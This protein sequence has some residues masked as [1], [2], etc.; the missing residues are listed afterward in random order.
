MMQKVRHKKVS[1][2]FQ[3]H[4]SRKWKG[5]SNSKVHAP[6]THVILPITNL[7]FFLEGSTFCIS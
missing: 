1:E 2:M 6:K 3:Y 4:I 7:P 5:R